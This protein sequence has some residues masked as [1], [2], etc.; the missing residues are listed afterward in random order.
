M[1]KAKLAYDSVCQCMSGQEF[2]LLAL[3][4]AR[5]S[6]AGLLGLHFDGR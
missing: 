1:V 2:V 4:R 3:F 5:L 6:W